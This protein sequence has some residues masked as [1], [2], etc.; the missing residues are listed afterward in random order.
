MYKLCL[1]CLYKY[2]IKYSFSLYKCICTT[3][4]V[5][6]ITCLGKSG[7]GAEVLFCYNRSVKICT[8]RDNKGN[9]IVPGQEIPYTPCHK[10]LIFFSQEL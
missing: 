6:H 3:T 2:P 4:D 10:K 8:W 1:T 9:M 5:R 7:G